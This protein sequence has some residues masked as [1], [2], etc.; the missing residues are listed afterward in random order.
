[1]P[2]IVARID[3]A[4]Y[5]RQVQQTRTET[6]KSIMPKLHVPS[7]K[8]SKRGKYAKLSDIQFIASVIQKHVTESRGPLNQMRFLINGK[9]YPYSEVARRIRRAK[10]SGIFWSEDSDQSLRQPS[11]IEIITSPVPQRNNLLV[12]PSTSN[13]GDCWDEPSSSQSSRLSEI[14]ARWAEAMECSYRDCFLDLVSAEQTTTMH[15]ALPYPDEHF[16]PAKFFHNIIKYFNGAHDNGHYVRNELGELVSHVS[17]KSS[18]NVNNFYKCCITAIDL[19]ERGYPAQ[20]FALVS[21]ALWLIEE[22]LE[23]RDPKL[24]DT[25]CDVSVTLLTKGWDRVYDVLTERVCSM[26]EIQALRK[27]Q[28]LEPWAQVFACLRKIPTTQALEM[29]RRGWQC[30]FDQLEGILPG[31]AWEGLN[32]SCSSNYELRMGE[33][34]RRLHQDIMSAWFSLPQ[35]SALSGMQEQFACGVALYHDKDYREAAG[36]MESIISRCVE[37]REQGDMLWVSLEIEA[38][39]VF[40][41]CRRARS[42]L[43]QNQTDMSAAVALIE[44]AISRSESVWGVTSATT[45]ALQHTLW[46]WLLDQDRGSEA[47]SL[48]VTI[49]AVLIKPEPGVEASGLPM[50]QHCAG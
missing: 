45:I 33:N 43:S 1:L 40:A 19:I 9:L 46:L 14:Y 29:M 11:H 5:H 2:Q 39:E 48:R 23:E 41:K 44:T 6:H 15:P 21:D 34:I 30:G 47:R 13:V 7:S 18:T 25:I 26:V 28:E 4:C 12:L 10:K 24:I 32:M 3:K 8:G 17:V 31:H 20:G 22:L 36:A 49:D 42:K 37:A 50:P 16:M 38:L 27:K 35:P